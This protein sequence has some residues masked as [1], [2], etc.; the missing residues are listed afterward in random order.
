MVECV[1]KAVMAPRIRSGVQP[2]LRWRV[3]ADLTQERDTSVKV[4][5]P[6]D[7]TS[8]CEGSRSERKSCS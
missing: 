6:R 5:I 1:Q 3:C 7:T 4:G 2:I 8:S